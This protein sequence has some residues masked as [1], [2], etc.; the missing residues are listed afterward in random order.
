[1]D[2]VEREKYIFPKEHF[3]VR[4]TPNAIIIETNPRL[5]R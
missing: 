5:L 3:I 2:K 1:M 4:E